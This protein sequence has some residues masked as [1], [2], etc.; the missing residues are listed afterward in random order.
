[1]LRYQKATGTTTC[2]WYSEYS[3][4]TMKRLLNMARPRNPIT[5]QGSLSLAA[6]WLLFMVSLSAVG[7]GSEIAFHFPTNVAFFHPADREQVG[8]GTKNAVPDAVLALAGVAR[9]VAH[10]DLTHS[11]AFHPEQRGQEAVHAAEEL[12]PAQAV[13]AKDAVG[14]A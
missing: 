9:V 2:L 12:D 13:A 4:W 1:M 11:V 8:G 6:I 5:A 7:S 14:A 10:G 3:H